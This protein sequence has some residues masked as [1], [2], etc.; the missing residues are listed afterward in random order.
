MQESLRSHRFARDL[1]SPVLAIELARERSEA[2][3]VLRRGDPKG[4]ECTDRQES[5]ALQHGLDLV[6]IPLYV[7]YL[8]LLD[9]AIRER[10]LE[11]AWG[12]HPGGR[13]RLRRRWLDLVNDRR[14]S[15]L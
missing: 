12:D 11:A 5:T 2:E 13:F 4:G 1:D 8:I 3:V 10:T 6:F 14:G 9:T 7:A 15:P